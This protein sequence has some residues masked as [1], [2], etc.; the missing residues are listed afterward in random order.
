MVASQ[1]RDAEFSDF[2]RQVSPSLTRT[3]W[4]LTGDRQL[5]ADLV[6]EAL[7]KTYLAWR[8]VR[9]GEGLAY[10]RRVLINLNIDRFRRRTPV[11]A[12]LPDQTE[13]RDAV[14]EIDDRDQLM[15]LLATLPPQQRRVLVLRYYDDLSEAA[16]A[17]LLGISLGAVKS[18]ASRGLSALRASAPAIQGGRS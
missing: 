10:S 6:Q 13:P 2:V 8:R 4:L 1:G 14:A 11:P 9:R 16:V 3:A 5:A 15:R 12:E 7:V 18:A 17:D